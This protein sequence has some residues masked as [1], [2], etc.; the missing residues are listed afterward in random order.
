MVLDRHGPP[1]PGRLGKAL[2]LCRLVGLDFWSRPLSSGFPV[3]L[4]LALSQVF[5]TE[6]RG[7]QAVPGSLSGPKPTCSLPASRGDT[8]SCGVFF[9]SQAWGLPTLGLALSLYK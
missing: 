6:T 5:L 9:L 4:F 1:M 2:S 8:E 3:L 7:L